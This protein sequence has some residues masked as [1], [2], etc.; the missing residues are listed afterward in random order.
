MCLTESS[1]VTITWRRTGLECEVAI[2]FGRHR[3]PKKNA[4][5]GKAYCRVVESVIE[6]SSIDAV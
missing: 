3:H 6:K 1:H 2:F 5:R 4:V